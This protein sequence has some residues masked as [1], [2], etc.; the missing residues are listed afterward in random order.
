MFWLFFLHLGVEDTEQVTIEHRP[1]KPAVFTVFTVFVLLLSFN[2]EFN[3]K[4]ESRSILQYK[5]KYMYGNINP[6]K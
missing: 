1:H 6:S 5:L 4:K 2:S 3:T